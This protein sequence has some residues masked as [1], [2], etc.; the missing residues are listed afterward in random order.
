MASFEIAV[1]K[2]LAQASRRM[3]DR[4]RQSREIV[5]LIGVD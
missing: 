4:W 2:A 1:V 5:S 3:I